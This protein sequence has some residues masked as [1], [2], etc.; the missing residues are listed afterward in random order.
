MLII[1]EEQMNCFRQIK[2]ES[3]YN[4]MEQHLKNKFHEETKKLNDFKLHK[5]IVE[6]VGQAKLFDITDKTDIKRFLEY[7]V[8]Y[9]QDFGKSS[10]TQWAY[11][12]L[13]N[14]QLTGNEK[15]NQIDE[16]DLF[17]I[18]LKNQNLNH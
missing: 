4:S 14:E 13:S 15:M 10:E 6:G 7:L 8:I 5:L 1:R 18:T 11:Q 9:S 2:L 3:F 17:E 16:Y 12:F